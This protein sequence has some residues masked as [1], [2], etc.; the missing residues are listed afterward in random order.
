DRLPCARG[1]QL[2]RREPASDSWPAVVRPASPRVLRALRHP[3]ARRQAMSTRESLRHWRYRF[4]A[5]KYVAKFER[6]RKIPDRRL[7]LGL[8]RRGFNSEEKCLYDFDRFGYADFISDYERCKAMLID[9][10][11]RVLLGDKLFFERNY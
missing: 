9:G 2:R 1:Q 10:R 8:L 5:V 3:Q 11:Y 4:S 7:D 6:R